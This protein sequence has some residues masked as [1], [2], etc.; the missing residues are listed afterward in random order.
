MGMKKQRYTKCYRCEKVSKLSK[1]K[2]CGNY[3]CDEHSDPK[4]HVCHAHEEWK[5]EREKTLLTKITEV[6]N[7]WDRERKEEKRKRIDFEPSVPYEIRPRHPMR[8][9]S[10]RY[11]RDYVDRLAWTGLIICFV[12][13]FLPWLQVSFAGFMSIQGTWFSM[14]QAELPRIQTLGILNYI[15]TTQ[16]VLISIS[17]L[18]PL[19]FVFVALGI[20][21]KRWLVFIGSM[22]LFLSSLSI[23]YYLSQGISMGG[24][25]LSLIYLAGIGLWGFTLGSFLLAYGSGKHM[26]F[27]RVSSSVLIT[28]IATFLILTNLSSLPMSGIER[29]VGNVLQNTS[30]AQTNIVQV[31]S[32]VC[33]YEQQ[34]KNSIHEELYGLSTGYSPYY[35]SISIKPEFTNVTII[36]KY[37][38]GGSEME[39]GHIN[40]N[41][42]FGS[43]EGENVNYLYCDS[44]IGFD[45]FILQQKVISPE[46][47]VLE[48]DRHK[49]TYPM[50]VDTKNN[51]TVIQ[52]NCEKIP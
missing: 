29:V 7:R 40:F 25:T 23:L 26:R 44:S 16:Y 13:L 10:F 36:G 2:Y 39:T 1:C 37:S 42:R 43:S 48:I 31:P 14:F 50:I 22:F 32:N 30:N 51:F 49:I 33:P 38:W 15:K 46:G 17:I 3:F 24:V 45:Y 20:F 34:L 41:C 27:S 18:I 9:P 52:L 21:S 12:S 5:D 35:S 6:F 19:G 47:V 11:R 4:D 8:T 28:C